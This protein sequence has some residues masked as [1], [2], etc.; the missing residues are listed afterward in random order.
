MALDLDRHPCFNAHMRQRYGRIHLPV[1]PNCNVQCGF[2]NRQYDCVNESRPGVTS[3]VLQPEQALEYLRL[4]FEKRSD[5]S[6]VGIAGPGD[7]F[8]NADKT[9]TTLKLVR[10]HYPEMLLCVASNGMNV[11]QYAKELSDLNVSHVTITVN[12]VDPEIGAKIYRWFRDGTKVMRGIKGAEVL[13]NRQL[14]AITK[15]KQNGVVV[16]VNSIILPTINDNHITAIAK[17]MSEL[18][19]DIFNAIPLL[20]AAGSDFEHLGNPDKETVEQ[21]RTQAQK[22][23]PQM[24]HCARCRADAA[25]ILGEGISDEIITLLKG[26]CSSTHDKHRS[27]AKRVAV[28]T[29]EDIM[30]N[31]HLGNAL[32]LSVFENSDKGPVFVEHRDTPIPGSGDERWKELGEKFSDCHTILVQFAGKTPREILSKYG[33]EVLTMEGLIIP[34]LSEIFAGRPLPEYMTCAAPT[35]C[36]ESCSGN[37][38]GCGA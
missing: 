5:I 7:P 17:K 20:P 21:I 23:I 12:A 32:S 30:V 27:V 3:S 13:L 29:M 28:A 14:E 26:C 35:R 38:G 18:G 6:V 15:L 2:C 10:D 8:A 11:A 36:G 9:L 31:Q 1:A 33:I 22:Y 37:G 24:R 4:V 34:A 16:K 19:V 25:G